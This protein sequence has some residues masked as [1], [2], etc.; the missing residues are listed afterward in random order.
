MTN[1]FGMICPFAQK[2]RMGVALVTTRLSE[3]ELWGY[4]KGDMPKQGTPQSF[5]SLTDFEG[6]L[7]YY[8][9]LFSLE[10]C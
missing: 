9:E 1:H 8:S 6:P 7:L 3:Q 5:T 4:P 2:G 10:V